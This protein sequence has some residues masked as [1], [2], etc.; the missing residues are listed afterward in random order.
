MNFDGFGTI[1]QKIKVNVYLLWLTEAV[2]QLSHETCT[3]MYVLHKIFN[4]TGEIRN[5]S[6]NV[7]RGYK[8]FN[9]VSRY[10]NWETYKNWSWLAWLQ[11]DSY[12]RNEFL[13]VFEYFS[14]LP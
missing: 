11:A 6:E 8:I 1:W 9:P 7:Y 4:Y 12:I 10:G 2:E 3:Y 14:E 13:Q 5:Q